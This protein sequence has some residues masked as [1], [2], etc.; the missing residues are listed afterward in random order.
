MKRFILLSLPSLVFAAGAAHAG[1]L[2]LEVPRN[3]DPPPSELTRAEVI[4]DYHVWRLSGLQELTRGERNVDTQGHAF[5]KA[6]ATYQYLLQSSRFG[7]LVSELE[8]NPNAG[9]AAAEPTVVPPA[10]ASR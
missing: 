5:R 7:V 4:A 10:L 2:N 6:D 1:T 3:I 9:V 8:G